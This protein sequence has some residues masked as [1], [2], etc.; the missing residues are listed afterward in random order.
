ME[1]KKIRPESVV[2]LC[3]L[4][5]I[6]SVCII[7]FIMV[8]SASFSNEEQLL[9]QGYGIVPRGFSLDAYKYVFAN[10]DQLKHSYIV[11]ILSTM[12]GTVGG[13]FL[14]SLTAYPLS[15][16][17]Y[18][19]RKK[20]SFY[21]YFTCLFSG[22]A[23]ASYILI[24]QYLKLNNTFAV[25]VIPSMMSVWNMFILRTYF[26]DIGSEV[27]ESA[28]V[29]GAGE[30]RIFFS[31]VLPMSQVGLAT[32][33][34][35]IML[36]YWNSW[37]PCLMY[38]TN[39]KYTTLQFFLAQTMSN[40][41]AVLKL[42]ESGVVAFSADTSVLPKETVRMAMCVLAVGPMAF[43]FLFFQRFFAKGINIGSVKG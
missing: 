33:G 4:L 30:Y 7:P 41:D 36:T 19:W 22:G 43:M 42:G 2:S 21:F 1:R 24:S 15:R 38:M 6:A 29:D 9:Q 17:D 27:I 14:T 12:I 37:Y 26:S 28:R 16:K 34:F 35:L 20:L 25:L 31:I 40:I 32:V 23:V 39:G 3:F 13:L 8:V 10:P 5:L 18:A 11:T